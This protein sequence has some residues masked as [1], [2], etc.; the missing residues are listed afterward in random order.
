MTGYLLSD[1][2]LHGLIDGQIEV[3]H[4]ADILRRAAASPSDR[5][6][7]GSW[8]SQCEM[9]RAA[10]Q[11]IDREP[12]PSV[13]DLR[14][15]ARLHAV[16]PIRASLPNDDA[17]PIVTAER[18]RM[19][20]LMP[21]L[22]ASVAVV[23]LLATWFAGGFSLSVPEPVSADEMLAQRTAGATGSGAAST[24][25]T[26]MATSAIPDLASIG[27]ALTGADVQPGDPASMVFRYRNAGSEQIALGVACSDKPPAVTASRAALVGEA[28]VW[29]AGRRTYA[30][31]GNLR[32]ERLK[33]LLPA[34]RDLA[35]DE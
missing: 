6:R 28:L 14:A 3:H 26:P 35:L 21:G 32:P 18:R 31:A 11:G 17:P 9:I 4:R 20:L 1:A 24:I 23:G 15:H 2:E 7:I 16:T 25:Q 8:Q 12:L 33:A 10:F 22:T 27:F 29:H 34:V 19:R 30:L 5:E 13:L